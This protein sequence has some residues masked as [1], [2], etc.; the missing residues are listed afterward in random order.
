[1]AVYNVQHCCIFRTY[2]KH[3]WHISLLI[4]QS[5]LSTMYYNDY[6]SPFLMGVDNSEKINL[7]F[8][9]TVR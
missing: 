1:V 2:I 5:R 9:R 6:L 4:Q 7:S 3:F 8:P